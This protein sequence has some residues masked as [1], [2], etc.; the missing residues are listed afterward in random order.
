MQACMDEWKERDYRTFQPTAPSVQNSLTKFWGAA[1]ASANELDGNFVAENLLQG[2]SGFR[3]LL[4]IVS[5]LQST[6][7]RDRHWAELE[8]MVGLDLR[9]ISRD[10][11]TIEDLIEVCVYV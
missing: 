10:K 4:P 1:T 7:L 9:C 8:G 2:V 5:E 11:L 6:V 3:E